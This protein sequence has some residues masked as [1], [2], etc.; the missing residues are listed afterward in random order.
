[1]ESGSG[2]HQAGDHLLGPHVIGKRVVVRRIVRGERGPSGG[3]ALTDVL[4]VCTAWGPTSC[5]VD[6]ERGP[7]T[8]A[9]AD[10][11]S[12]KPVPPRPSVRHRVSARAAEAHTAALFP[13][14]E[15]EPLGGW[16]LRSHQS[17]RRRRANSCLAMGEP[18]V[19]F[20]EAEIRDFYAARGREPLVQVEADG[21]VERH[22][23]ELGWTPLGDGD[24]HFQLASLAR[25]RR[26]L[27]ARADVP[28]TVSGST[29][30]ATLPHATG[31]AVIDGDWLALHALHVQPDHRRRGLARDVL[32][33]L[34]E[35]GA[36]QGAAT[37]WLHVETD[38][39][40]ALALYDSLGFTTHHTCRYLR[41]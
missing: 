38:N 28:L 14:L 18:G 11:V 39:E 35:W 5:V 26:V 6:S 19:P 8:I 17:I 24:A 32:A 7:V 1:M 3:P 13:G 33:S 27:G 22:F 21:D 12:G 2:S 31:E 9:I 20:P 30:R 36:E 29:A 34:L 4:G 16:L 40:P 41:G 25:V 23:R 15:T 10:I 37:A